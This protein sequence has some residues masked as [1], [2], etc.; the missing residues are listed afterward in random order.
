MPVRSLQECIDLALATTD[1]CARPTSTCAWPRPVR[2]SNGPTC[3]PRCAVWPSAALHRPAL[4]TAA[5]QLLRRARRRVP[6]GPVRYPA[7][8]QRQR[9]GA[10]APGGSRQLGG[11]HVAREAERLAGYR[12]NGAREE[13]VLEVSNVYYNAQILQARLAFL[14]SNVVNTEAMLRN[15]ELLHDQ[16]LAR[17]TDV[18]RLRLQRDQLLTQRERVRAQ[19]PAGHGRVAPAHGRTC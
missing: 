14:D 18:D 5:G 19:L 13:V 2:T 17:G 9:A 16:S 12:A 1:G 15:V 10:T 3:C 6:R 7:E 4:P 11:I 8:H